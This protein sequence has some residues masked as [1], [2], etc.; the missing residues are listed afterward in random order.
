MLK[1]SKVNENHLKET[2][3]LFEQEANWQQLN[4]I[5]LIFNNNL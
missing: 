1:N 5:F 3:A 4:N 2:T